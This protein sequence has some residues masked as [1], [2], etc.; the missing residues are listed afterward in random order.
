[1]LAYAVVDYASKIQILWILWCF[2]NVVGD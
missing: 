2:C 1:M